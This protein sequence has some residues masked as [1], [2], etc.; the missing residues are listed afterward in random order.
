MV[1]KAPTLSK[2]YGT[3]EEAKREVRAILSPASSCILVPIMNNLPFVELRINPVGFDCSPFRA[4]LRTNL[5]PL[6]V[7][8]LGKGRGGGIGSF[9][10]KGGRFRALRLD[11]QKRGV[12]N[13]F[14]YFP[15]HSLL[16]MIWL[17][18]TL[19]LEN[20]P[21]TPLIQEFKLFSGKTWRAKWSIT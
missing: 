18:V 1:D 6:C 2:D 7:E 21:R 19:R 8:R 15:P 9:K 3:W 11:V 5:E 14:C 13:P 20:S 10:A 12:G 17:F 4:S 16:D